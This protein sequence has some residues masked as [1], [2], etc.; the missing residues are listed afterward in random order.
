MPYR[1]GKAGGTSVGRPACYDRIPEIVADEGLDAIIVSGPGTR[2]D[3]EEVKATDEV[4]ALAE[5]L[6][7]GVDRRLYESILGRFRHVSGEDA[8][9]RAKKLF[10]TEIEHA[11]SLSRE[12]RISL[13][14]G[15]PERLMRSQICHALNRWGRASI[16]INAADYIMVDDNGQILPESYDRISKLRRHNKILVIDGYNVR[17][18]PGNYLTTFK[19]GGSDTT[20][21]VFTRGLG[22]NDFNDPATYVNLTDGPILAAPPK[23][24]YDPKPLEEVSHL[25][26][27]DLTQCGFTIFNDRASGL[28][29][30]TPI[31]LVVRGTRHYPEKGTL[32]LPIREGGRPI[33][34]VGYEGEKASFDVDFPGLHKKVGILRDIADVFSSREISI[35]YGP[36]GLQ[37]VRMVVDY[38]GLKENSSVEEIEEALREV[39]LNHGTVRSNI[40]AARIALIGQN[41]GT[42]EGQLALA[43]SWRAVVEGG[44]LLQSSS[45]EGSRCRMMEVL[46]GDGREAVNIVYEQFIEPF[47]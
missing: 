31:R 1:I 20:G 23:I 35:D 7:F 17:N 39:I 8:Y 10:D 37:N 24:V 45:F 18:K 32:V 9:N 38:N 44:V 36:V 2:N 22:G 43:D 29:C 16:E 14:R 34:A 25:E 46:E 5:N 21:V 15:S 47:D 19:R 33:L 4:I 27:A 40:H 28:L 42:K 13:L 11:Q 3:D 6:S 26:L 30:G 12:Q 41:L